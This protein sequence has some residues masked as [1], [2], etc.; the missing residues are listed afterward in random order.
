M[1]M[2]I[3][4]CVCCVC[5]FESKT[6]FLDFWIFGFLDFWIFGFCLATVSTWGT[7]SAVSTWENYTFFNM[8]Y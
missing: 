8:G 1:I 3:Q 2:L 4:V 7:V 6:I 5:V